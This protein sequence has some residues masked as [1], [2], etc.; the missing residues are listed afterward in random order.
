MANDV[1]SQAA[2]RRV[3]H[4]SLFMTIGFVGKIEFVG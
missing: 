1:T 2:M 3:K 4:F